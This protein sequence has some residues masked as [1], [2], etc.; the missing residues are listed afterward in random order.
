MAKDSNPTFK[1]RAYKDGSGYLVEAEWPD[2]VVQLVD[3]F[4][5]EAEALEWIAQKSDDWNRKHPRPG[6]PLLVAGLRP[7]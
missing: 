4:G 7:F 3:D 5:S 1:T 2:G 6:Q